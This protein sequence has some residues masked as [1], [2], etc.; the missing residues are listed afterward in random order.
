MLSEIE[1]ELIS[2][3]SSLHNIKVG[4]YSIRNNGKTEKTA[5]TANILIEKL[6]QG[7]GLNVLVKPNTKNESV[8]MPVILTKSGLNDAVIN[9]FTIGKGADVVIVAGCGIHASGK[10][11]SSHNGVHKFTLLDNAKVKYIE[12]HI[13]KGNS[14]QKEI[15][16]VTEIV[17]G[18]GAAFIMES[19]QLGGVDKA[20]RTTK[21]LMHENSKLEIKESLYTSGKDQAETIFECEMV[22]KGAS[23]HIVSRAVAAGES[24][25][26][27]SSNIIGKA[28]CFGHTECDAIIM[29]KAKVMAEPKVNAMHI[30]ASLVHEAAIGKIAGEEI[31][32]L[33]TLGL[34]EQE[35]TEVIIKG[36]LK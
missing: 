2:E 30:D 11:S 14:R 29:D 8:H 24:I 22:G 1:Q 31:V 33:M 9:N 19:S 20:V 35:A 5:S 36:F 32:K 3:I 27:Y 34:T 21:I 16:P 6:P 18:K 12:K 13:G 10:G 28:E 4:A 17:L 26:T 23:S 7:N 25:Q 15:S